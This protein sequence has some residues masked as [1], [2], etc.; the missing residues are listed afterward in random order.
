MPLT[1]PSNVQTQRA[2]SGNKPVF[3]MEI[4]LSTGTLYLNDSGVTVTIDGTDYVGGLIRRIREIRMGR[5]IEVNSLMVELVNAPVWSSS[6]R[7]TEKIKPVGSAPFENVTVRIY[8]WF[9]DLSDAADKV[10]YFSGKASDPQYGTDDVFTFTVSDILGTRARLVGYEINRTDFSTCP[11]ASIGKVIPVPYGSAVEYPVPQVAGGA[12]TKLARNSKT[13]DTV[14]YLEDA[15]LFPA[16][17]SVV[18]DEELIAYASKNTGVT[19]HQLTGLTRTS[20]AADHAPGAVV[21]Q[22]GTTDYALSLFAV[23]STGAQLVVTGEAEDQRVILGTQGAESAVWQSYAI[24]TASV[25]GYTVQLL[26]FGSSGAGYRPRIRIRENRLEQEEIQFDDYSSSSVA[27]SLG[28]FPAVKDTTYWNGDNYAS[29]K[30]GKATLKFKRNT[31]DVLSNGRILAEAFLVVDFAKVGGSPVATVKCGSTTLGTLSAG[32]FPPTS[33]KRVRDAL[34]DKQA[35]PR[36]NQ[37]LTGIK[38]T[39]G[40]PDIFV[41]D[42]G[43]T[44]AADA[45]KLYLVSTIPQPF[46]PAYN[47]GSG[48][49]PGPKRITE[50][51]AVCYQYVGYNKTYSK[52]YKHPIKIKYTWGTTDHIGNDKDL[53]RA[54]KISVRHG[55]TGL[56]SSTYAEGASSTASFY[57]K[58][59]VGPS[60]AYLVNNSTYSFARSKTVKVDTTGWIDISSRGMRV[61]D[62]RHSNTKFEIDP[63]TDKALELGEIIIEFQIQSFDDGTNPV[64]GADSYGRGGANY[65]DLHS[66][67]AFRLENI[68]ATDQI[69]DFSKI[70]GKQFEIA[71]SSFSGGSEIRIYGVYLV[72]AYWNTKVVPVEKLYVQLDGVV[73][74]GSGTYTGTPNALIDRPGWVMNHALRNL[75]GYST[76]DMDLT[77]LST[78]NTDLNSA[79]GGTF[80]WAGVLLELWDIYDL[81][82]QWATEARC[83]IFH[84]AGVFHARFMPTSI[85]T[86]DKALTNADLVARKGGENFAPH[87][88]VRHSPLHEVVNNISVYYAKDLTRE[89]TYAGVTSATDSGSISDYG[90]RRGTVGLVDG[91]RFRALFLAA[92]SIAANI[93]DFLLSRYKT[94]KREIT[95]EADIAQLEIH[96]GDTVQLTTDLNISAVK[97]VV[98]EAERSGGSAD[99]TGTP[100]RD[101]FSLTIREV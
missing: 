97:G 65:T 66:V 81:L 6:Q 16:S 79:L 88:S 17:G 74:N 7:F 62:L 14:L 30:S 29:L 22:Y 3:L 9:R 64:T 101:R 51:A 46:M 27:G 10:L 71:G 39:R 94:P 98:E 32:D 59:Y 42:P 84:K 2:S 78:L 15:S 82:R 1:L 33:L 60:T 31:N 11:D 87:V 21:E 95:V 54:V 25:G 75:M 48:T 35:S 69:D 96:P 100:Q 76:S 91:G 53:I 19:P 24:V 61:E 13:T 49:P 99:V 28:A 93:R 8:Q 68:G 26:R 47:L 85:G 36:N 92:A 50:G 37:V 18:I 63:A 56:N 41:Y 34:I 57:A 72:V 89:D 67:K 52:T 83:T 58:L 90:T 20:G 12:V 80:T 43:P 44:A 38:T 77:S 55:G 40:N 4:V 73:D 45:T 5:T 23:K 86:A 70:Y